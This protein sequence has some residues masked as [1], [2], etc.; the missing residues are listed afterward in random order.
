MSRTLRPGLATLVRLGDERLRGTISDVRPTI[1][2]G[3][4]TFAAIL[5]DRSSPLLKSNLRVDVEVITDQKA[6]ALRLGRGPAVGGAGSQDVFVVRGDRAVRV[7]VHLG[8]SSYDRVEVVDG[9]R[10]GELVILSDMTAYARAKE[11]GSAEVFGKRRTKVIRLE[12]IEKVYRTDSIETVALSNINLDVAEGEF[13]SIMG[14][15]GCGRARCS[16]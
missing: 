11:I 4:M 3:V 1:Q 9:L 16:T 14:P 12:S 10:E 15:S 5:E 13:V 8:L 7:P 2:N 6:N